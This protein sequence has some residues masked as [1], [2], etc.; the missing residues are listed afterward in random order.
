MQDER[1]FSYWD[2]AVLAMFSIEDC[3][4][5]TPTHHWYKVSREPNR[6][7]AKS[8]SNGYSIPLSGLYDASRNVK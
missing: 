2:A 8:I 3:R 5:A 6:I 4:L 1:R 7:D